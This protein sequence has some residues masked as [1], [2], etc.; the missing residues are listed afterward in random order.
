[1]KYL[2]LLFLATNAFAYECHE[3]TDA[4]IPKGLVNKFERVE[5]GLSGNMTLD[6]SKRKTIVDGRVSL[7]NEYKAMPGVSPYYM[8][9]WLVDFHT[10]DYKNLGLKRVSENKVETKYMTVKSEKR[11]HWLKTIGKPDNFYTVNL[12]TFNKIKRSAKLEKFELFRD[13]YLQFKKG[14]LNYLENLK[15]EHLADKHVLF[16]ENCN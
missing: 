2:V 11:G 10:F 5:L 1:M 6:I 16:F 9:G 8:N 7:D 14:G 13:S 4:K 12:V 3:I 15:V